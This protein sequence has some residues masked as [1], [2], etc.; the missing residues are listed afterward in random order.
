MNEKVARSLLLNEKVA[1]S[2]VSN[3]EV[4]NKLVSNESIK[5]DIFEWKIS[6]V[7]T[8]LIKKY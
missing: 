8:F 3:Q 5:V 4:A 6:M 2:T 7:A 1:V